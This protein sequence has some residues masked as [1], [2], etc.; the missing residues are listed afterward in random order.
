MSRTVMRVNV[1]NAYG[2]LRKSIAKRLIVAAVTLANEHQKNL[3]VGNPS[4][5]DTPSKPGEY[6]RLRTG[7]GRAQVTADPMDVTA[8]EK[9][10]SVT[11]SIR[12]AGWYLEWLVEGQG[13]LGLLDTF[14]EHRQRISQLVGLT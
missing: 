5:H 6:P 2:E 12:E 8:V 10:L 11:V 13:R 14:E 3:S 4:P 1:A 7:F 9:S